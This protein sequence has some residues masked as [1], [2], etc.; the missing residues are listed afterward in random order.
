MFQK[1]A[2]LEHFFMAFGV[3]SSILQLNWSTLK[4]I[5]DNRSHGNCFHKLSYCVRFIQQISVCLWLEVDIVWCQFQHSLVLCSNNFCAIN[6]V[7]SFP[8]DEWICI[9]IACRMI[10]ASIRIK[11]K[12]LLMTTLYCLH[13]KLKSFSLFISNM[14]MLDDWLS[15][16]F[17]IFYEKC[18]QSR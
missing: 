1:Y 17:Q 16:V 6:P 18:F 8:H 13:F 2:A 9:L 4:S 11:P 12:W 15:A 3:H 5:C 10:L 7:G 14:I